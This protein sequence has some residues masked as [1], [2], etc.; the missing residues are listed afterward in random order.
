MNLCVPVLTFIILL[1]GDEMGKV[2]DRLLFFLFP[3]FL[4]GS[5]YVALNTWSSC[6]SL[7]RAGIISVH[8]HVWL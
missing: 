5:H 2:S 7:L 4:T 1:L 3:F 6:L 8:H